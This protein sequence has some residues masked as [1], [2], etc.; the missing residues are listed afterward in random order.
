MVQL[1]PV[2]SRRNIP[3]NVK[4]FPTE[5]VPV[6]SFS[7]LTSRRRAEPMAA[8]SVGLLPTPSSNRTEV[9]STRRFGQRS[10]PPRRA[11]R[12][13]TRSTAA[14]RQQPGA[15]FTRAQ[16]PST[17]PPQ[18]GQRRSSPACAPATWTPT[19]TCSRRTSSG[20]R[21]SQT[22][23]PPHGTATPPTTRWIRRWSTIAITRA[24]WPA[25]SSRSPR[26]RSS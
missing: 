16:S 17:R 1:W 15:R 14:S 26:C 13:A 23:F 8:A 6:A 20:N 22:A 24:A 2:T 3:V 5:R 18:C 10:P 11:R 21:P 7:F 9:F 19:H 4:I 12:F 25:R